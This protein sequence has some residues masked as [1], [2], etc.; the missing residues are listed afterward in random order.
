MPSWIV[1]IPTWPCC[2][3]QGS[4][5]PRNPRYPKLVFSL[6]SPEIFLTFEGWVGLFS[7]LCFVRPKACPS[8]DLVPFLWT[9][10]GFNPSPF[11]YW[12][13]KCFSFFFFF[14]FS[15]FQSFVLFW[16]LAQHCNFLDLNTFQL[17]AFLHSDLPTPLCSIQIGR[18]TTT[19]PTSFSF[20]FYLVSFAGFLVLNSMSSVEWSTF[21]VNIR[22]PSLIF[23]I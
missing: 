7:F 23:L 13:P 12:K 2:S 3:S 20:L 11:F 14:F 17:K 16:V 15:R 6:G 19:I 22:L 9:L 8:M 1:L 4:Q 5:A 18:Y 21:S 10:N